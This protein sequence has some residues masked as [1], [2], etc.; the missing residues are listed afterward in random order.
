MREINVIKPMLFSVMYMLIGIIIINA[1][2]NGL[3]PRDSWNYIMLASSYFIVA[4]VLLLTY[5][6]KGLD[7]FEPIVLITFLYLMIF[8]ITPILNMVIDETLVLGI[9]TMDGCIKATFVFLV[10]YFSFYI[11]YYFF[12]KKA[13][14]HKSKKIEIVIDNKQKQFICRVS[15]IIWVVCYICMLSYILSSGK[16]LIYILSIGMTGNVDLNEL[17]ET[18]IGFLAIFSYSLIPTWMYICAYSNKTLLKIVLGILTLVSFLMSGFRFI[19]I[20]LLFAPIIYFYLK[21]N[22][23][24]R[25]NTLVILLTVTVVMIGVVGFMRDDV[26]AGTDV[27]WSELDT[28]LIVDAVKGN[29]D[30]YMPFYGLVTAVPSVH[31]YTFG[32]QTFYTAIMFVPRAIWPD[33]P[34]PVMKE[35]I[36][37]SVSEYAVSA[38]V[39]WPNLGEFYSEFGVVGSILCMF[40]FGKICGW[41]KNLYQNHSPNDHALI[42]YSIILPTCMQLVIRGYS[43]S[44]FYLL[45][46]LLLPIVFIKWLL[47]KRGS[48]KT[49]A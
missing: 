39:A 44:N 29:F 20:I 43:P 30:I 27:D 33:K 42:A 36:E 22:T 35:L 48:E 38:G 13:G 16:N 8:C 37:V 11:G 7:I 19:I 41:S 47:Q 34:N 25:F 45:L 18:P 12:Q 5:L 21:H 1:Y 4:G 46:F 2:P 26:R 9:D 6:Q 15:L 40:I 3:M 17:T 28:S 10:S 23:R 32:Q 24:P 31:N 49:Y 14:N